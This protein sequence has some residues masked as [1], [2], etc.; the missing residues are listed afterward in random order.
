LFAAAVKPRRPHARINRVTPSILSL[1]LAATLLLPLAG[2]SAHAASPAGTPVACPDS[3]RMRAVEKDLNLEQLMKENQTPGISVAVIEHFKIVCARGYGV[4][5]KDS[6][7]PV[8]PATLFMAGSI[9]K[10][11]A[12]VGALS[13]VQQG[14]L[15]LDEDVNLKL[16]TWKIP[17]NEYTTKHRVTLGL[18]L[19]HTGGFTGGEFF[20]GYAAGKPLPSLLHILDGLS[21]ATND[22]I[23]VGYVPGT[24]WHYSGGGYL[25][26]QQVVV[27]A[28]GEPFPD[29]MRSAVFDKLGMADTTY[30][31][32]L[33]AARAARAAAGTLINGR[34]VGGKWHVTPEMAAA[35][36]WSTP[37][38]LAKLGIEL[39]LSAQGKANHVLTPTTARD[40]LSAHWRDGVINILG[41]EDDPDCMGYGFFV[42]QRDGR[43]GH[44]GGNVGYQ[45]TLVMFAD[46]GDGVVIMTNSDI[47]LKPGNVL[48]DKVAKV[49]GWNY[50]A[51]PPP[52]A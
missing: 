39:A 27:D 25:V 43:F 1:T 4:A 22:P 46:R 10:P 28:S 12:A 20:P 31:E 45:A 40:M 8:T 24:R 48:L 34:P 14:K 42:G 6:R 9:S 19:E 47:G 35:G 41:T 32:P 51:P 50:V 52:G 29:F 33:P 7:E 18:L 30:E 5:Q 16:K 17:G 11:V 3:T 36:L 23:R 38:D 13:L 2:A 21:P 15:S 37:T 26:V 44:I 49:Y